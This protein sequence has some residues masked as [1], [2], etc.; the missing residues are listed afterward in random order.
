MQNAE[1]LVQDHNEGVQ[2]VMLLFVGF[3]CRNHAE[4]VSDGSPLVPGK[5]HFLKFS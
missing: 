3:R 1:V 4:E 5:S 2:D